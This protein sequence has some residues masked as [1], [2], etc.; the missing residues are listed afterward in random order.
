MRVWPSVSE[1]I[2]ST[3]NALFVMNL[4]TNAV[5]MQA[6]P[7]ANTL[8][9]ADL[10]GD[11]NGDLVI[12]NSVGTTSGSI[13]VMLGKPDG[14]FG[15]A[16]MYPTAGAGAITAVIDDVNNDGKLDIVVATND[17][18]ISVLTGKGDG[19]FNSAR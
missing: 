3:A 11:G 18:N 4:N 6:M 14:T 15:N 19:S 17:Q 5:S 1:D 7:N 16:V 12:T 13:S 9:T 2:V 8:A 10:N